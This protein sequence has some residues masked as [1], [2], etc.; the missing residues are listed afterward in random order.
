MLS[1]V[2]RRYDGAGRGAQSA[3][4]RQRIID[5]ARTLMLE[6]GYRSTTVA[7]IATEAGVNVDTLYALVGRKPA[8]LREIVEQS[9]SGV[10]HAVPAE[11]RDYVAAIRAEPDGARKLSIYAAAVRHI[12][13]RLAPIARVIQEAA[14]SE[15]SVAALWHDIGERRAENM[16]SFVGDVA[17]ATPLRE[18][19][20]VERA[21]D[22]VWT[23][24]SSDVYLLLTADRGWTPD[25]YEVWLSDTWRRLLFDA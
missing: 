6:R 7:D 3:G 2:K 4:T 12:Q 13:G 23:L 22:V 20:T 19:L 10:D 21:A 8:I 14:P 24:N 17:A 18:D 5:A 11:A 9:I 25:Q 1:D 15:P 16:R